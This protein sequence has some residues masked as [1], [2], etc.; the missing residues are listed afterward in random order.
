MLLYPAAIGYATV[1]YRLFDATVVIR[2]SVIYTGAG[3]PHHRRLRAAPGRDQRAAGPDRTSRARR[4]S[5]P[6]SCS[7]SCSLF[8][9]L[10]ERVR[11]AVDRTFFRERHDYALAMRTLARSMSSL[12]DLDEITRRLTTTIESAMHVRSTRLL[13]DGFPPRH[14][15]RAGSRAGR[16]LALPARRRSEL[17]QRPRGRPGRLPGAG[18]RGGGAAPLPGGPARAAGAG[19]QALRGALYRRGSR[20]A[21]GAG[22]PGRGRGGQRGGA[23]P[24]AGLRRSSS[25]AACSSAA[26]WPSSSRAACASSSRSR[27]RRRRSTSGDRRQRALRRHQRLHAAVLAAAARRPGRRWSSATSAPSSTRSSSTAAT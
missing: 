21:R 13:V 6:A 8:N 11:R 20:D 14:P 9:P 10:R 22:R 26:A 18:R 25:S 1:R 24:G 19:R 15:G 27:R 7:W 4:G 5:R 17:R 23:P 2:R 16:A 12:L 3:R